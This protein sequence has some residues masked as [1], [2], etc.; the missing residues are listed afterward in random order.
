MQ[1]QPGHTWQPGDG[2]FDRISGEFHPV[3][4]HLHGLP[5]TYRPDLGPYFRPVA[6]PALD[7]MKRALTV[8]ADINGSW[9]TKE[10]TDGHYA[11][12]D[13]RQRSL[14]AQQS[15]FNAVAAADPQYFGMKG[16]DGR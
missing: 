15:L 12:R 5:F 6:Q 3:G 8:L 2:F 4:S 16:T 7:A 1:M 13:M 9:L 14:H 10:K 11:N